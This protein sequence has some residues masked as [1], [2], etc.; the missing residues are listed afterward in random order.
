[1]RFRQAPYLF[2]VLLLLLL[3]G[4]CTPST[5]PEKPVYLHGRILQ[6]DQPKITFLT[7]KHPYSYEDTILAHVLLDG[8][9]HFRTSFPM[10]KSTYARFS[11]GD[12]TRTIYLTPGDSLQMNMNT[13][14]PDKTLWFDGKGAVPNNYLQDRRSLLATL[15]KEHSFGIEMDTANFQDIVDIKHAMLREFHDKYFEKHPNV[16]EQFIELEEQRST[17]TWARRKFS[18][19]NIYKYQTNNDSIVFSEEYWNFLNEIDLND[20]RNLDIPVFLKFAYDVANKFA[21]DLKENRSRRSISYREL[22]FRTIRDDFNGEVRNALLTYFMLQQ[23]EFGSQKQNEH[24]MKQYKKTIRDEEQLGYI[25]RK[26]KGK[27]RTAPGAPVPEFAYPGPQGDT[28]RLADLSGNYLYITFWATWS[29]SSLTELRYLHKLARDS[30]PNLR[31]VSIS[32]DRSPDVLEKYLEKN[33]VPGTILYAGG[34]NADLIRILKIRDIPH[35]ILADPEGKLLNVDA[36][37]P[38]GTAR[39][40]IREYLEGKRS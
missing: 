40:V 15:D 22:L 3:A 8:E 26:M 25:Q 35:C 4:G 29:E 17:F 20:P 9:G 6:S 32:V 24:L 14:N 28:T 34:M 21:L 2:S 10:R 11:Y 23:L 19:P 39:A 5:P 31:F 38:S 37:K 13:E 1:M 33:S 18:Y 36:P 27:E 30:F 16:P 7:Q 12:I